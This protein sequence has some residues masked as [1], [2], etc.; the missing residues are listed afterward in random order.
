LCLHT[1]VARA[2]DLLLSPALSVVQAVVEFIQEELGGKVSKVNVSARLTDSPCILVTSQYGWSANMQR[3]MKSQPMGDN[4]AMDY[5]KGEKIMEINPD[6]EVS[7]RAVHS[8]F[9]YPTVVEGSYS[10]RIYSVIS[11]KSLIAD[12]SL[13][14]DAVSV[15]FERYKSSC[16]GR[17]DLTCVTSDADD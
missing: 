10:C 11:I 6:N 9:R 16:C 14:G 15:I 13:T 1:A 17:H 4:R 8:L 3:I 2:D 12:S 7:S 5:M